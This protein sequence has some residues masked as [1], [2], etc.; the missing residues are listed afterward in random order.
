MIK[1]AVLGER[2][3]SMVTKVEIVPCGFQMVDHDKWHFSWYSHDHV[4]SEDCVHHIIRCNED[5]SKAILAS[6]LDYP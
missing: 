6:G 1:L 4:S 3:S 5:P 2:L